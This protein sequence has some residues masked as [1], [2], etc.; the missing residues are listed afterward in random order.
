MVDTENRLKLGCILSPASLIVSPW[1]R[2]WS[3]TVS[4]ISSDISN[5]CP[6][7]PLSC[8]PPALPPRHPPH[9]RTRPRSLTLFLLSILRLSPSHLQQPVCS[10]NWLIFVVT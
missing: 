8:P 10:L 9:I 7:L 4:Q 6:P 1:T 3:M 2:R 5:L